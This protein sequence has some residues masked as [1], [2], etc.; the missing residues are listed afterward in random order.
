[1]FEPGAPTVNVIIQNP[2]TPGLKVELVGLVDTGSDLS[3]IPTRIIRALALKSRRRIQITGV[4]GLTVSMRR[5]L[6]NLTFA[7]TS[8]E[9]RPV[10]EWPGE[11]VVIG[12]DL[13]REC[14]FAYDGKNR[15]FEIRDP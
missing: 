11:F 6:V 10:I 1:M 5:F 12:R 15:S 7:E 2:S 3:A 8:F 9:W 14:I 4:D 13:L